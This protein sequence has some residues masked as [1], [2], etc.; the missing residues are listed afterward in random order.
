MSMS[1][2]PEVVACEGDE[3]LANRSLFGGKAAGLHQ[4][5]SSWTP[6]YFAISPCGAQSLTDRGPEAI[7]GAAIERLGACTDGLMVRSSAAAEYLEERGRFD[8]ASCEATT[9]DVVAIIDRLRQA[10]SE[11]DREALAFVVQ[12]RVLSQVSGHLS[13]ERR[14]SRDPRSWLCE[15][16]VPVDHDD[17]SFR[18]RT[19]SDTRSA[20][21]L[22]CADV[23]ELG[24]VLRWVARH[25]AGPSGT[26]AHLEW[27]W[28][29][30]R[31]WIVQ[32]DAD[33]T[34]E[35]RR[36]G[37]ASKLFRS[38]APPPRLTLFKPASQ[39]PRSTFP[40]VRH[41][42]TLANAGL[43]HGDV[44]VLA[45]AAVISSL[46]KEH[47]SVALARDLNVLIEAPVVVR[48][49][50]IGQSGRPVLMSKRT[51][52]CQTLEELT[53]FLTATAAAYSAG[54]SVLEAWRSS[55]TGSC[56]LRSECSRVLGHVRVGSRSTQP[57][58]SPTA[59]STTRT[60]R[61]SLMSNQ[62]R[63]TGICGVSPSSSTSTRMETGSRDAQAAPGT[64]EL[65]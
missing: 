60:I 26:R 44:Y 31:V 36:P 18:F 55:L 19:D 25:L 57:G 24:L 53:G 41:V 33:L 45:G 13:N 8:S 65:A 16:E 43:P 48:T 22:S 11:P 14:V 1:A 38:D 59:S 34:P 23:K 2:D 64:G 10:C 62:A 49:D 21:G 58:G 29:G 3:R 15:A 27:V 12:K 56:R 20:G 50:V 54:G 61:S 46:A 4:L 37:D 35:G 40:K 39:L 30:T 5:P 32:R 47:V 52:T 42:A 28:D 51:D 9:A 63:S 6:P 7:L 17:R